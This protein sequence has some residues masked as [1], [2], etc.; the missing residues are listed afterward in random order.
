[1]KEKPKNILYVKSMVCPRCITAVRE[2]LE[3]FGVEILNITLGEVEIEQNLETL[4][5]SDISEA[6]HKLGFELLEDSKTKIIEKI[7]TEI[8]AAIQNYS[9]N[10]L[11]T[12]VLSGFLSSR[13]NKDYHSLSSLFSKTE[14]ITIEHFS[15]MQKIEKAKELLKYG[16]HTLSEI[17]YFLGY[18][19]V[20]HLSAQFKQV[21]GLTASQFKTDVFNLRKTIDSL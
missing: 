17:S 6:L 2:L 12:M 1:M 3:N 19:S 15:I 21:T 7:K 8:I 4:P 20:Q 13:L 14:G 10:E 18:S 9:K 5:L 16:E 11:A